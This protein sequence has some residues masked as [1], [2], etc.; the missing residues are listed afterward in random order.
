MA[1]LVPACFV[2]LI[3]IMF[4]KEEF[5]YELIDSVFEIGGFK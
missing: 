2:A 3:L 4:G 1:L 5:S